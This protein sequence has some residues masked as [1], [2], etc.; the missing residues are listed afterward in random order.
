MLLQSFV[1]LGCITWLVRSL[2]VRD[3]I[4]DADP[5][6][7]GYLSNHNIQPSI[8][9]SSFGLLWSK[10]FNQNE[11]WYTKA[12]LYTPSDQKQLVSTASSQNWNGTVDVVTGASVQ[13]YAY[14][15]QPSFLQSEIGRTDILKTIGET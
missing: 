7:S 6:Q 11:R 2:A 10:T 3:E 5:A 14:Q 12:L 9:P 8:G 4:S 1:W 13:V 15:V